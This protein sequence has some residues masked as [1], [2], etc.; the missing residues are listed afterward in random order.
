MIDRI[1]WQKGNRARTVFVVCNILL[2][3]L[4]IVAMLVPV[5]KVL[6]DSLDAKGSIELRFTP[7]VP[8][9]AAYEIIVSTASL[10]RP[11]FISI[12]VTVFGTLGALIVTSLGAYVLAQHNLPGRTAMTYL[13]LFTMIFHGGMIP[14]YM[15]VRQLGLLDSLWAVTLPYLCNTYFLIL[16]KNF[17]GT[18]PVSLMESAEIDG[19]TPMG[20]LFRIVLPL[21]KAGLA[22]IGLFYAVHFWNAYFPYVL[23]I[24]NSDWYNFQVKLRQMILLD[25][26][27]D[28]GAFQNIYIRT[29]Q[30]AAIV[31]S[32]IPVAILYPFLQK[33]FVKGVNLGAIKG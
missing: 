27:V 29:L 3:L 28:A 17:F 31:V 25:A 4:L 22:A 19:C 20:I 5:A 30:N 9:L 24:N 13:I 8:T 14:T 23:Y 21:S 32:I 7:S 12:F 2:M 11:F 26:Q 18:I 10:Y 15:V 16:L 6:S 33:H 1:S